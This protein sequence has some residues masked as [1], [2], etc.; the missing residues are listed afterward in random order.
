MF[1][2]PCS[3]TIA[4][5][6]MSCRDI[7]SMATLQ[8]PLGMTAMPGVQRYSVKG[9]WKLGVENAMDGYHFAPT[10]NTFVGYL[11]ESGYAVTDD[12]QY[13]YDL[14]DGHGMLRLTGHGGRLG[15]SDLGIRSQRRRGGQL[16]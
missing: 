15:G 14:G 6:S 11:R 16:D 7:I 12:D 3:A 9:N 8:T 10:H 2:T 4:T 13:A 5:G 1:W